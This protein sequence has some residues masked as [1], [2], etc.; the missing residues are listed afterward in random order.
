MGLSAVTVLGVD[1]PGVIAAVT[2]SL[3]GCGANIQDSTMTLLGGHVAMMLLVSGDLSPE[4]LRRRVSASDLVVTASAVEARRHFG[5]R[6]TGLPN[7]RG[8]V[9][10]VH[11]PDRPGIISAIS[12]ELAAVGGHITGMST[13]LTGRLYV[14]IADVELPEE[15]DV[16]DLA[17]R[18]AAVGSGLDSEITLRR[19]ESHVL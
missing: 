19:V 5:A 3:A 6:S 12:A 7:G 11:G 13:R 2:G 9:L 10:T 15:V 8:H 14:L 4:D 17:G 16:A 18:L 1:R